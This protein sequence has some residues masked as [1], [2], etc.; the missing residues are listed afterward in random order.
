MN[1]EELNQIE[2]LIIKLT[3]YID[4]LTN[5]N[6]KYQLDNMDSI[7]EYNEYIKTIP[8]EKL[9]AIDNKINIYFESYTKFLE[10]KQII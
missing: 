8:E 9:E 3:N 10:S 2:E 7:K 5:N 4:N 1:I 6:K